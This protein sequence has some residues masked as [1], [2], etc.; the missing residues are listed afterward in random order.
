MAL[1]NIAVLLA[2]A[3]KRVL[4]IDWDM[5]APGLVNYFRAI[6]K[7]NPKFAPLISEPA[8]L[9]GL[10]SILENSTP[11]KPADWHQY[12]R[13]RTGIN[14]SKVDFIDSGDDAL[15][16]SVRLGNFI[17]KEFF[18]NRGGAEIVEKLRSQ[19]KRDYDY[20]LVDS[21]TGLT[22]S[23]GICTIQMPDILVLLF[24]ANKQNTDWCA[25]I[26]GGIRAGRS[27]LHYDREFLP[28]IPVLSR[29][30]AR[31]ESDR[32]GAA[33]DR[34]AEQFS[35]FFDW[36]PR[37]IK[38]RD[39]L[40]GSVLP[41][42]P[43]YNFDEALAVEDEP[44]TGKQGLTFYYHLLS[45]LLLSRLQ[46]GLRAILA[47]FA[48]AGA[49]IRPFLP[50]A[51]D[52]RD[53][54]RRDPT[55]IERYLA[56]IK[57]RV[58]EDPLEA[59]EA[60]ESLANTCLENSRQKEAQKLLGEA[61]HLLGSRA[62]AKSEE[63]PRLMVRQAQIQVK[64]GQADQSLVSFQNALIRAIEYF[65]E[66][67]TRTADVHAAFARFLEDQKYYAEATEQ[68]S[69]AVKAY[70]RSSMANKHALLDALKDWRELLVTEEKYQEL[71]PVAKRALELEL[72][73]ENSN[74]ALKAW[75]EDIYAT[76]LKYTGNMSE[77]VE[78]YREALSLEEKAAYTSED[79]LGIS[80]ALKHLAEALNEIKCFDEAELLLLHY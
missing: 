1:A 6:P 60:M 47:E 38:P 44:D 80:R 20:V 59:A 22:D 14:D 35:S 9:G 31:E 79:S 2:Q 4:C 52:L 12:I 68:Y 5:E 66:D 40:N 7:S 77:A 13:T 17:W 78:H 28:I 30:D 45:R 8:Q 33:L 71:L 27:K 34:I 70:E 37:S 58:E 15:D 19:W 18:E 11:G 49:T 74:P 25:R 65:G 46:K 36:L 10:L 73:Q 62:T 69:L 75:A 64:S 72:Q 51:S 32:A 3:N 54:L 43:R 21:R 53:E 16:F 23:S 29:F 67:D 48:V 55:T 24:A 61:I 76:A 39:M 50:S 41:Y 26:A 63:I 57:S 42:V 56:E